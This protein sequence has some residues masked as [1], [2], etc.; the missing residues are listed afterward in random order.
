[1]PKIKPV[2]EVKELKVGVKSHYE[3]NVF[4]QNTLATIIGTL[5][6]NTFC[7]LLLP[8]FQLQVF[9]CNA[10]GV[11]RTP[12]LRSEIQTLSRSKLCF[13]SSV[14][15]VMAEHSFGVLNKVNV[16]GN[17]L[18]RYFTRNKILGVPKIVANVFQRRTSIS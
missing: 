3:I 15:T 11:W 6:L 4:L 18:Q 5:L 1:L 16:N 10:G 2:T 9:S 12:D 8:I 7:N 17:I 13:S 14:H